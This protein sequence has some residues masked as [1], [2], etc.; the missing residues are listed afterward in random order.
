MHMGFTMRQECIAAVQAKVLRLNSAAISSVTTGKVRCMRTGTSNTFSSTRCARL[1][2]CQHSLCFHIAHQRL[3]QI[4]WVAPQVVNLVS[5]DVRRFDEAMPFWIFLWAGPLE[6]AIVVLMISLELG[7]AAAFAGIAALLALIPLQVGVAFCLPGFPCLKPSAHL[8]CVAQHRS[9]KTT[10]P[11]SPPQGWL[12]RYIGSLRDKTAKFTDERVRLE[13]EA[14]A[15]V[16]AMKVRSAQHDCA[17][18]LDR[19]SN[20]TMCM[21]AITGSLRVCVLSHAA[22]PADAGVGGAAARSCGGRAQAGDAL[23]RSHEPHPGQQHGFAVHF[24]TFVCLYY[25]YNGAT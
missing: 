21:S 4:Y 12:G 25:V 22:S 9:N 20:T 17:Q 1:E 8:G 24:C 3:Y 7:A 5:N 14:I 18:S 10:T 19:R 13:G 2:R 6:L 11:A 15:G 16:L 23:L